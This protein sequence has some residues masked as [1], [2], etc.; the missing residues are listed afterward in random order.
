[1]IARGSKKFLSADKFW[2]CGRKFKAANK[3]II[4]LIY[5]HKLKFEFGN[6]EPESF[7]LLQ[8]SQDVNKLKFW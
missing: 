8:F 4:S 3:I 1:M 6:N 7:N 2:V 5:F